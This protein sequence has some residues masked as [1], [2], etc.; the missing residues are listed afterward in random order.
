MKY[1]T[2]Y[3]ANELSYKLNITV[4]NFLIWYELLSQP[5]AIYKLI[6]TKLLYGEIAIEDLVDKY[7]TINTEK[8]ISST[9]E[10]NEDIDIPL[11]EL[12]KQKFN[13]GHVNKVLINDRYED[14]R[15][16]A[17]KGGVFNV[18]HP[19]SPIAS[20]EMSK[21]YVT[22]SFIPISLDVKDIVL[23]REDLDVI[24]YENMNK[25][26]LIKQKHIHN[27]KIL[28]EGY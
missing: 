23:N 22:P 15:I 17:L 1:I 6:F 5:D 20:S 3:Q 14:E 16:S 8:L 10:Y 2:S 7:E 21:I 24:E 4:D 25:N 11:N 12:Y 27:I 13:D 26:V 18:N 28:K 19:E 9:Y